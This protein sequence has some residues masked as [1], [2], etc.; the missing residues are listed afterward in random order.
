MTVV[1][2]APKTAPPS[3]LPA[4]PGVYGPFPRCLLAEATELLAQRRRDLKACRE[5]QAEMS[6]KLRRQ[7][8]A[9]VAYANDIAEL[10]YFLTLYG[11]PT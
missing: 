4:A 10:E 6:E 5:Y 11:I 1:L 2:P 3:E 7:E 9:E 8:E